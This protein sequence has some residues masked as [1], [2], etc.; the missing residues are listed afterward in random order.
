[1]TGHH[2]T[3]ISNWENDI[4]MPNLMSVVDIADALGVSIDELVGYEVKRNDL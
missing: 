1:M 3:V 4:Q 2:A